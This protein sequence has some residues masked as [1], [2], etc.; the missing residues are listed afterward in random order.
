LAVRL[1]DE[2][3]WERTISV[4]TETR[5]AWR[6]QTRWLIAVVAAVAILVGAAATARAIP[7]TR[8]CHAARIA[9]IEHAIA[10]RY[11][12]IVTLRLVGA[13]LGRTGTTSLKLAPEELLGGRC[14]RSTSMADV[15]ASGR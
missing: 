4:V 7:V 6:R 1:Y 8:P 11:R 15:A 2:V 14:Y 13:G 5:D 9:T 12:R 10:V 3:P